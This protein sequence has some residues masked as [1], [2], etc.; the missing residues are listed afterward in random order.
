[1][2]RI[3]TFWLKLRRR[4]S[5]VNRASRITLPA[6][7]A[8][9]RISVAGTAVSSLHTAAYDVAVISTVATTT[10]STSK[11]HWGV[12]LMGGSSYIIAHESKMIR[13]NTLMP[14]ATPTTP[15]RTLAS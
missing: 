5:P 4:H 14:T 7:G 6:L 1:M 11:G 15:P 10:V 3:V 8:R 9:G 13:G 2:L 12:S